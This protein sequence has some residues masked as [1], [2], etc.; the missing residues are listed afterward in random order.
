MGAAADVRSLGFLHEHPKNNE[1]SDPTL[2][3]FL[4]STTL[5]P[6]S[7]VDA[8]EHGFQIEGNKEVTG[9]VERAMK[10]RIGLGNKEIEVCSAPFLEFLRSRMYVDACFLQ[11]WFKAPSHFEAEA[12]W[13]AIAAFT[14]ASRESFSIVFINIIC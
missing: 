2:S 12:W 11:Y 14:R 3:L 13:H 6:L 1:D 8:K 9:G 7:S 4:P 5:G 10:S